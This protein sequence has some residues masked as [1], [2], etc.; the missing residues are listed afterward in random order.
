[1]G[2]FHLLERSSEETSNGDRGMSRGDDKPI[3]PLQ[4]SDLVQ[5]DGYSKSFVMPAKAE[6]KG[7]GKSNWLAKSLVLP[8][9][10]VMQ[11]IAR[12]IEYLPVLEIVALA[13]KSAQR[14]RQCSTARGLV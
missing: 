14:T 11:C 10:F 8:S 7:E 1:M 4:A 9:W 12:A 5:F 6:I 13:P 3:H 2:G